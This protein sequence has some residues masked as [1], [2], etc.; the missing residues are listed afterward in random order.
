MTLSFPCRN[1][2]RQATI[3][4]DMLEDRLE[5]VSIQSIDEKKKHDRIHFRCPNRAILPSIVAKSSFKNSST[6]PTN[7]PLIS[8]D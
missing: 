2:L 1:Q 4:I 7:L 6:T 8:L 5:Q 3:H